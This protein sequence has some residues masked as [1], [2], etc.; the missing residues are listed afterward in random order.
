MKILHHSFLNAAVA[1]AVFSLSARA[2]V[3]NVVWYHFGESDSGAVSGG[4][5]TTTIDSAAAH[6]LTFNGSPYYTNDVASSAAVHVGSTLSAFIPTGTFAT[7]GVVSTVVSNFGIEAWVKPVELTNGQSIAY[8]GSTATT[9]WGL[10]MGPN[11]WYGLYGGRV[12]IDAGPAATGVWTHLALVCASNVTIMYVNGVPTATN[13]SLPAVPAGNFGVGAPPQSPTSQFY[14]G[15]IDE[16]RVFTFADG[17]FSTNDLLF[18]QQPPGPV[19]HSPSAAAVVEGVPAGTTVYTA[20]A[21]DTGGGPLDYTLSGPDA[22]YFTINNATGAVM[23]NVVPSFEVKPSY[24]F[25]VTAT[26]TNGLVSTLPVTLSV[27]DLPPLFSSGNNVTIN[28]GI[29]PG[30]TVYQAVANE[31]GGGPLTYSLGGP[32]AFYFFMAPSGIVTI[33]YMPSYETKSSYNITITATEEFGGSSTQPVTVNVQDLPPVFQSGTHGSINEGAAPGTVVYTALA[34]E[35][36]GGSVAY[37]LSG[38]DAGFFFINP[39]TGVVMINTVPSYDIKSS[40]NLSVYA[41]ESAPAYAIQS[42]VIAVNPVAPVFS[43]GNTASVTE[44]AAAGTAIYTAQA[45]EPGGSLTYSLSGPDAASFAINALTGVVTIKS[46]PHYEIKSSYSLNVVA[47][48]MSGLTGSQP[49]TVTVNPVIASTPSELRGFNYSTS[50]IFSF[51]FTNVAGASFAALASTNVGLPLSNWS[52]LGAI[53]DS[54]PGYYQFSDTQVTNP[55]F[56]YSVRSP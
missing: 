22:V 38:P 24:N 6:N 21:T 30:T 54:P 14:T 2:T 52:V 33:N 43:S 51:S 15:G 1:C 40:Y 49:V 5:I 37:S 18:F 53:T 12:A 13:S 28:E 45:S 20:T 35:P 44:G 17:Q 26:D 9:G 39:S 42:L 31:P 8:N 34:S 48:E 36:G 23:I 4:T 10:I 19:F 47:L 41:T 25:S 27:L 32:D 29:A 55:L 56:F 16:L 7:N 11:D 3:T 50:G 46:V